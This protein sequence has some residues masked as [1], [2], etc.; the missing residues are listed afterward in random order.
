[1]TSKKFPKPKQ[2][3]PENPKKYVGD[4]S[5]LTSR[6][7]W[8]TR[9]FVYCDN[10]PSI[11]F[12][13]SEETVIPYLCPTDNYTKPHRYFIDATIQVKTSDGKM[14]T[15]L[16]EIKPYLQTKAPVP[17]KKKQKTFLT[18]VLTWAKNDA[19]WKATLDYCKK[20]GVEFMIL[21]EHGQ[22]WFENGV[23]MENYQEKS[24]F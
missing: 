14:K 12:W 20:H 7:S 8:E 22:V 2:F 15:Y 21:T 3:V 13:N 23:R 10:S 5:T 16:V 6:S 11:V 24:A 17:G 19:K 18:E 9:F 1:M 4:L